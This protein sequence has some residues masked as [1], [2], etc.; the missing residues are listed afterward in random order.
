MKA[1]SII[2]PWPWLIMNYGKDVENR[3]WSTQ[4]RG[5]LLIHASK[6][7]DDNLI[8]TMSHYRVTRTEDELKKMLGWCGH[9]FGSVELVDCVQNFKSH[10]AEKGMW[11]WV[12]RD[13]MTLE[14]P[15]PARGA[16]GL[17]EYTG[18]MGI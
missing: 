7:P 4:Y 3:S 11:H 6:K 9:I 16:L 1:L 8:Q 15:V 18:D 14:N 12:L 17:W 2:M 5:R 13:P 10:W